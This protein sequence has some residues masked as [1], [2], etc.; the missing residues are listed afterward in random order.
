MQIIS[1]DPSQDIPVVDAVVR[2]PHD[3]HRVRLVFDTGSG[4]TQLDTELVD[5]LGYSSKDGLERLF[6]LSATGE[7]V[8]GYSIRLGSLSALGKHFRELRIGA[9]DFS[10]YQHYRIHGLLG[11]DIIRQLNLEM[12]GPA[13]VLKVF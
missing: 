1:F 13:G 8:E 12:Q 10:H 9:F 3:L 6:T 11:W 5:A 4:L 2:G 7:E